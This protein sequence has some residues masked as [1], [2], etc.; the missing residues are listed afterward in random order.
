MTYMR[1]TVCRRRTVV[2]RKLVSPDVLF[3][4]FF[5]DGIVFP[6]LDYFLFSFYEIQRSIYFFI[7]KLTPSQKISAI[8]RLNFFVI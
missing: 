3:N 5:K 6:E 7:H 8:L 1:F 4:T 2:K